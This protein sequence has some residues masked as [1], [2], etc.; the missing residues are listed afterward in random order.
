MAA[1][2]FLP[3]V[4]ISAQLM[5]ITRQPLTPGLTIQS[6]LSGRQNPSF[7]AFT[8]IELLVVI[9]I[10]AIL[11]A[12]LLP[13][14]ARAKA[15]GQQI[16]CM[17]NLKQ[18]G[19]ASAVYQGDYNNRLAWC[20]NWGAAWGNMENSGGLGNPANIWMQDLFQPYA[21]TN[22]SQ[23][24]IGISPA[25]Y[26]PSQGLYTCP[27]SLQ[28]APTV[29]SSDPADYDYTA[30]DFFYNNE[31]VTYVWNHMYWDPTLN[32][33]G[34]VPISNRPGG[35]I[36]SPSDAILVFESPYHDYIYMPHNKAMNVLHADSSVV[37]FKGSPSQPDWWVANSKYGWDP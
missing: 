36:V 31:G 8:L 1:V 22:T 35:R 37:F 7:I 23:P 25:A 24:G 20:H 32:Y 19:V 27:S 4:R 15:K 33:Y 9:A 21:I 16:Y 5:N 18:I 26:H 12:L 29:P 14:L 2:T 10:I 11:A 17:N 34:P 28:I 13:A 3:N 6:R 30:D